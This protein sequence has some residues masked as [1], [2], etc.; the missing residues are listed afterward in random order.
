VLGNRVEP[1]GRPSDQLQARIDEAARLYHQGYFKMVLVS[2]GLG[3]EGHSEPDVMRDWLIRE[4]VP[5]GAIF[6]DTGGSD[7]YHTARN[8]ARF[9][10]DHHLSSVLIV[11]QYFHLA[12]CQLAFSRFGISPIYTSHAPFITVRDF[13]SVPRETVGYIEYLVR[14]YSG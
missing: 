9:L 13:Y 8:T 14:S 2:G 12:R 6:E 7:T 5:A 4:G 10:H 11:S 1:D 3:R